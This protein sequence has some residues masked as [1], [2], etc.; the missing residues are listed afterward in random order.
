MM[1][2]ARRSRS[3]TAPCRRVPVILAGFV[4]VGLA[5]WVRAQGPGAPEPA[6]RLG[7]SALVV[8]PGGSDLYVAC[9]AGRKVLQ[10]DVVG[11]AVVRAVALPGAPSGLA[12]AGDGKDLYA[13]CGVARSVVSRVDLASG[14]VAA[15]FD[16]GYSAVSPVLSA[17]GRTLYT[18][19]RFEDAVAAYDLAS[20]AEAWR[21][22]VER[23]PIAMAPTPDGRQ[24][25]VV[26]HLPAG[27]ADRDAGVGV[28]VVVI[29]LAERKAV[30]RLA[31]PDGSALARE[32][33]VSP[34]G[35]LAA[36][37]HNL[38]RFRMPTTQLDRGWMN[39]AALT[40]IDVPALR[41]IN[42]VLLD[43]VDRGAANPW[44]A[45]WSAD[46]R[47][48]FLT[49]AGTHELSSIEVPA[50]LEKLAGL[51]TDTSAPSP[52][53]AYAAS[54]YASDVP[55]DLSFLVGL[56]RRI[57]LQGLG[58]RAVVVREGLPIVADTFSDTLEIV[59]PDASVRPARTLA[60]GPAPQATP[61]FEG[62]LRFN[63]ARICF[64]NW[65]SCASCHSDDARVDGLNWDL[66]ND[67]IGSPKNSKSLV[68]S[69]RTP[70]SMSVGVRDDAPT[71]VR[72]GLR[73]ILFLEPEPGVAEALDAWLAGLEP[74]P[75]PH[76]VDGA[77]S[78]SA[79]RGEALF[80]SPET[81]CAEC[82]GGPART[83]LSPHDVGTTAPGGGLATPPL[84]TPTLV[85]LWRTAPYLHDGSAATLRDVLTTRNAADRHGKTSQLTPQ[86]V[87]DLVAYLNSL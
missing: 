38:A 31:L 85:E 9:A 41:V 62:E 36:V 86:Q 42:T 54:R 44:G 64:Q 26:H 67:G 17:D 79:R 66:L 52:I 22:A 16:A 14:A 1:W 43:E 84:D 6:T 57:P 75:S 39:T 68:W 30:K 76:L 71:A 59:D 77:L 2:P 58:P 51:P 29:D 81:R 19:Q 33:R 32:V 65:Q 56:R 78:E 73:N 35:R 50:L 63:D 69:H 47:R 70:P 87:D 28:A 20:G 25:L 8:A 61:A 13:T 11:G 40:L 80:R 10:V 24:L 27:R 83:D 4:A 48:L 21:V 15:T 49:H 5:A 7:P 34:D 46:G 18:A 82:H 45:A 72:A 3:S 60:L 74:A 55:N 37:T 53:A 12:L 23:E